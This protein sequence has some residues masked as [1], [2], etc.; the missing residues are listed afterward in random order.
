L[1]FL[2]IISII[3]ENDL[4]FNPKTD[5]FATESKWVKQTDQSKLVEDG[6]RQGK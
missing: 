2:V 1:N 4:N 5:L 3:I 6:G